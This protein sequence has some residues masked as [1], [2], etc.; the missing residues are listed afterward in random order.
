MNDTD[1]V[2]KTISQI[3]GRCVLIGLLLV[4]IWFIVFI[5]ARD[6]IDRQGQWFGLTSHE[7]GLMAY[8]GMGLAK[9]L[10]YIFFLSP[11]IAIRLVLRKRRG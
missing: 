2:L 7:V 1:E 4:I 9:L 5:G 8:G 6:F 11:Y 3:L 10:I